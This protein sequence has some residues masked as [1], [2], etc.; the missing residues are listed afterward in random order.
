[1]SQRL[2]AALGKLRQAETALAGSALTPA[3][4]RALE[5]FASQTGSVQMRP[6][7]R[8]VVF[9]ILQPA[10]VERHWRDLTPIDAQALPDDLPDR[11]SNIAGTRS[12]KGAYHRH[13]RHYLLL[14]AGPGEVTWHNDAGHRLDLRHATD[15]QGAGVLTIETGNTWRAP[16]PLWLVEN[17][18]LFDRLDWLPQEHEASVIGSSIAYYSGQLPTGLID[19]LAER[20]RTS[21]LW[22]F[23]D[24]DGVG[25]LNYA[26]LKAR[27]GD[28]VR[29]WLMPDWQTRLARFGSNALW[30][31]TAREFHAAEQRLH[32]LEDDPESLEDDREVQALIRAM[33]ARGLALEQEAVWLGDSTRLAP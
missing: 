33:Q 6:G 22:C 14:K 29:L 3:Q 30:R 1:V 5:A 18:A 31:E 21:Q 9:V 19:W 8:G 10:I 24:Y 11:A 2:R 7:G 4:R 25:L 28:G 13:G 12:S 26:R 16:G 15:Q 20:P 23:P 27:L 17:Q 32:S